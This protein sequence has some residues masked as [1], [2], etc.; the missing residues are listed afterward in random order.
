MPLC[1]EVDILHD[2]CT[3]GCSIRTPSTTNQSIDFSQG[4]DFDLVLQV[5]S[6]E[7]SSSCWK[8]W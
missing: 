2:E 1:S 8:T 3:V 6:R 4:T 7:S 5:R